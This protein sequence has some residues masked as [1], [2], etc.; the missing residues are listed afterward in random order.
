MQAPKTAPK[1]GSPASPSASGL[2]GA[3]K[4]AAGL[5]KGVGGAAS[6][7]GLAI[8]TYF[9]FYGAATRALQNAYPT[10]N[11]CTVAFFAGA[12]GAMGSSFVKVP[13]AVCIRSVQAG[14]YPNVIVAASKITKVAGP[15]GLYTGYTPTVL[16]D[17]PDMAFKFAA[18]ETMGSIYTKFTGKP[19]SEA[20]IHEDLLMGGLAGAFSAA[21]TTPVDVVKTRMM[22]SASSRPTIASTVRQLLREKSLKAWFCGVG[23]RAVSNGMNSAIFFCIFEIMRNFMKKRNEEAKERQTKARMAHESSSHDTASISCAVV[24]K[25]RRV[26]DNGQSD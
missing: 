6:G 15:K 19:R 3:V 9:A 5:Y 7:A 26:A 25:N 17:I 8:G 21:A 23:P 20:R 14:L 10:M 24:Q 22:C 1:S 18:Y 4:K 2:Q 12:I 13:A 16:E 11:S